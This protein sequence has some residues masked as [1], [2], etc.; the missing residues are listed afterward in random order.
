[1][2]ILNNTGF[3]TQINIHTHLYDEMHVYQN[4]T[5]SIYILNTTVFHTWYSSD[6]VA[7]FVGLRMCGNMFGESK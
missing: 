1:M 5:L 7:V 6:A 2:C 4:H 3:H